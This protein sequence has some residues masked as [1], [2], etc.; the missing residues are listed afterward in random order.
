VVGAGTVLT[1]G[2]AAEAAGAGARFLVSPIMDPEVI[3]AAADLGCVSVPGTATPTEMMTADRAGADLI[4]VFPGVF[5]VPG[6]VKQ[7]LGPL[8]H[9]KLFPTSG[10]T[11]DNFVPVLRAGA[12][13]VGFVASLFTPQ[14]LEAGAW[15]SIESRSQ[16]IH[17]RLGGV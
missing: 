6:F 15:E 1:P 2:A 4:K 10:V 16:S 12:F 14:D 5:D 3:R 9:L 17:Q 13:G 11:V 7:V 8:P